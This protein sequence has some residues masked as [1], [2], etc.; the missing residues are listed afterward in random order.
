MIFLDAF[1]LFTDLNTYFFTKNALQETVEHLIKYCYLEVENLL[2]LQTIGISMGINPAP[3]GGNLHLSKHRHNFL[4]KLS[5]KDFAWAKTFLGTFQFVDDHRFLMMEGNFKSHTKICLKELVLKLKH[6]GFHATFVD[7][8]II[9]SNIKIS[10]LCN[11]H[12]FL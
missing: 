5:K 10:K 6:F 4:S 2:V 3:S 8:D 11:K 9:I 7:L 12:D 1:F